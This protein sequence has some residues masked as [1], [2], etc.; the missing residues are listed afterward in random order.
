MGDRG[1]FFVVSFVG[2]LQGLEKKQ[3]INFNFLLLFS[4]G[5]KVHLETMHIRT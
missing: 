2:Q 1:F 5:I 3:I 4:L